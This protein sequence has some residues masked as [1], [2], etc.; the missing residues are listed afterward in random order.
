[1]RNVSDRSCRE[2]Q[3][4]HFLSNQ[5]SSENNAVYEIMWKNMV[6]PD[7]PQTTV[8]RL[9]FACGMAEP[10]APP[11]HTHTRARARVPRTHAHIIPYVILLAFS[12]QHWL[13]ERASMLPC[14]YIVRHF[15]SE[16][17]FKLLCVL[18]SFS[19]AYRELYHGIPCLSSIRLY[20]TT[21][22]LASAA[23]LDFNVRCTL[24]TNFR[25]YR[26]KLRLLQR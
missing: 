22:K 21:H 18:G 15:T 5:F 3:N 16:I 26:V 9:R 24:E 6:Q 12:R 4:T 1:M 13:R 25:L 23:K 17:C 7:K 10:P 14:V 11:S 2:K 8:R 20:K 19:N